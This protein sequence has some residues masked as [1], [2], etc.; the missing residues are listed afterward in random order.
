MGQQGFWDVEE[1][2]QKL[3]SKKDLLKY[4]DEVVPWEHFRPLI[5]TIRQ[6]PSKSNAGRRPLMFKLL[7]LQ[8]L[9][10]IGDDELEYQVNDRLSF[11]RFL[12]LGIEDAVPDAKTVWSFRSQLQAKGLVEELFEQFGSYLKQE[13][14]QALC[15]QI[16]DATLVPVPKQRN[17]RGENAQVKQG[18]VPEDW[19]AQPHKLAQKDIDARSGEEEWRQSLRL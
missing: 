7:I 19:R 8:Q 5:E 1:R 18:E 12:H 9:Y 17:R 6:K 10:N 15:G 13:G 11:M 16:F 4:L 2:H 3:E 14:Y